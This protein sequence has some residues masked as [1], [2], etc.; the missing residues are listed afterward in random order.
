MQ[1]HKDL[2]RC[3]KIFLTRSCTLLNLGCLRQQINNLQFF[4]E[5][6]TMSY[7]RKHLLLSTHKRINQ[8]HIDG[9]SSNTSIHVGSNNGRMSS[10]DGNDYDSSDYPHTHS[11]PCNISKHTSPSSS[12]SDSPNANSFKYSSWWKQKCCQ[13]FPLYEQMSSYSPSLFL[14]DVL[15]A[16]TVIFVVVP[17]SIAC[18]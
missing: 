18:N 16:L 12:I 5:A 3:F 11:D 10:I 4:G 15:A 17:G 8:S 13:I 2:I 1:F 9:S 6:T 7:Q 14:D